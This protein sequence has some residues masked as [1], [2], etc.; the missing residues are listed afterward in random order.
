MGP[1]VI[2]T[3]DPGGEQ[4]VQ[5]GQVRD[6]GAVAD[7]DQE[8]LADGA[9][10]PLDLPPALRLTGQSKIIL[11]ITDGL[12][13]LLAGLAAC[14]FEAAEL[15]FVAADAGGDGFEAAA[16]LVDLHGQAGQGGGIA[17]AG[18]VLVDERAQ[19]G[20]P[21]EGRPADAGED[22]YLVEGDG[23]PARGEL[24]AGGLDPGLLV[25]L[26]VSWHGPG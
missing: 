20:P 26:L 9:E 16:Q 17:A 7:L 19:V 10:E 14:V 11:W 24:G 2:D 18:T 6:A 22:G 8:L 23:L 3:F 15:F 21:V 4:P 12:R 1:P 5:R 25:V 13:V